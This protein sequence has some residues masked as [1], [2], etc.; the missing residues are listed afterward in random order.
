VGGWRYFT[1]P[2]VSEGQLPRSEVERR[3]GIRCAIRFWNSLLTTNNALLSKINEA[4]LLLAH[5][6]KGSWTN[7]PGADAP[8]W[9]QLSCPHLAG[10]AM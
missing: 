1:E 9:L 8:V 10:T 7:I 4:D 2:G 3:D 6:T 5:I